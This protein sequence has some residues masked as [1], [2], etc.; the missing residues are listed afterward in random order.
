MKINKIY[1]DLDGC[2]CNFKK[3]YECVEM[4][5]TPRKF[6]TCVTHLRIFENLEWMPNGKNLV[7][8]LKST[9]VPV[10]I[11]TSRGTHDNAVGE[12]AIRQ[13]NLWLDN[14]GIEF[15]RNFVKIGIDK[16]NYSAH[17][18]L[19]IDDTPK[20]IE[21]FSSGLGQGILYEDHKFQEM[22]TTIMTMTL[23]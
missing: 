23:I 18:S 8:L 11:L 22:K 13:K 16:R 4:A 3:A 5:N 1:L 21:A 12:E 20:V 14:N 15:P 17:G 2:V 10:E 9:G 19:L 7:D 6:R